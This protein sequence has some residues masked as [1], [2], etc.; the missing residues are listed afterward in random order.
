MSRTVVQIN[1]EIARTLGT[2]RMFR[3]GSVAHAQ[4]TER[5]V[6]LKELLV[7]YTTP[8]PITVREARQERIHQM[9]QSL[10]PGYLRDHNATDSAKKAIDHA[11][12]FVD[13]W[14][15]HV[16]ERNEKAGA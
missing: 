5:L 13:A 4:S 15:K 14:D 2:L 11:T 7:A 8:P 1:D 16:A 10:F 3:P 6:M 9:A 12:L